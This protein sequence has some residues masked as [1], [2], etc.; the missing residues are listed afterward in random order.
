MPRVLSVKQV[1]QRLRDLPNVVG[2]DTLN[3]PSAGYVGL[4]DLE[5]KLQEMEQALHDAVVG[6]GRGDERVELGD[7]G[8]R[9]LPG[10][11]PGALEGAA[12]R[13]PLPQHVDRLIVLTFPA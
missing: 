7:R 5:R 6:I 10:H 11:R 2:Y 4:A 12:C 9:V 1:A 8:A 13:Q 3:E